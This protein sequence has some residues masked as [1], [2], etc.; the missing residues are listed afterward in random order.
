MGSVQGSGMVPNNG[1]STGQEYALRCIGTGT[2]GK[3]KGSVPSLYLKEAVESCRIYR[4]YTLGQGIC[5]LG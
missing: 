5:S 1:K 4:A 2:Y 3:M